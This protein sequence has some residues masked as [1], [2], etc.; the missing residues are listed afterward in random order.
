MTLEEEVVLL[1]RENQVFGARITQLQ[2]RIV[3][4]EAELAKA[5][6]N[7]GNSSKP[8]SSD[9]TR[10]PPA[11]GGSSSR[12]KK[13]GQPGHLRH[14]R[15]P[16]PPDQVDERQIHGLN[17]CPDC[18]SRNLEVLPEPAQV[19]QQ[20]ELLPK[21]F[22]V[23]EHV[24]QA[25]RCQ[26]C[27]RIQTGQL[28]PAVVATGLIGPRMMSLLLFLKG[29]LRNSYTGIAELLEH[30]L[31]FKVCRG[32]LAKVMLRGAQVLEP[33]VEELRALL[34]RE[35]VLNV[36]ET[37]HKENGARLWTWCFRAGNFVVF[38]IQASR[39]SDVLMQFLGEEF[40]GVLGCDYFSAYRKFMGKMSGS[41]QFCFAHLIRDLKFL[42]EHPKALLP[43]Y[44]QPIL[45]AIRKMFHLIHEQIRNP[46]LDFQAKLEG[47]KKRILAL[48]GNTACLSPLLW[49]VQEHYSEVFNMSE[50]FRKHGEAYFSFITTPEIGPTNNAAEQA[51]R[52][53][54]M[55]RRATQGTRSHK[56]RAFC[57]RIWTVVGTCR[58]Q[59]RSIFAY[60]CQAVTAWANGLPVPSLLPIPANSARPV[61]SSFSPISL[62]GP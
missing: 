47:Q 51:L 57:E 28:P 6:K 4:L 19:L 12:R 25:C 23:T 7:S 40:N 30:V 16:F 53:V 37:G 42:A 35:R 24:V 59:H 13:G 49:Y 2:E 43:L 29:A 61:Y 60:L 45:Q 32:Y 52:F 48:A 56:G 14:E 44:A 21:P 9:I 10:T 1:R 55:D 58:M 33:V 18:G 41:V 36:D 27:Q 54:V 15:K 11:R 8:P 50:R 26:N 5:K 31:G 38:S 17:E 22:K 62:S 20:V 3:Q 34:P 39:G 46:A